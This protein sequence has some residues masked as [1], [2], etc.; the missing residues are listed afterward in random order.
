MANRFFVGDVDADFNDAGNWAATSGGA[1]GA[2]IPGV[3]D[4]VFF[5]ANSP[6]CDLD[7]NPNVLSVDFTAY[8]NEI[9]GLVAAIFFVGSGGAILVSTAT[10]TTFELKVENA[11][12]TIDFGGATIKNLTLSNTGASNRTITFTSSTINITAIFTLINGS[13]GDLT[14][15]FGINN[16]DFNLDSITGTEVS[17]GVIGINMGSGTWTHTGNSY[18]LAAMTGVF[19]TSTVT[20]QFNVPDANFIWDVDSGQEPHNL[21][22]NFNQA[23]NREFNVTNPS[24]TV[25]TITG[26]FEV[27]ILGAGDL[28]IDWLI[29]T[30][31]DGFI[32]EEASTGSLTLDGTTEIS[33]ITCLAGT[34]TNEVDLRGL[35]TITLVS[36]LNIGNASYTL[37]PGAVLLNIVDFRATPSTSTTHTITVA[38]DTFNI[39]NKWNMQF[40]N[41]PSSDSLNLIFTSCIVLM[42]FGTF[43][44]VLNKHPSATLDLTMGDQNWTVPSNNNAAANNHGM[45]FPFVDTLVG[46]S[47]ITTITVETTVS[48]FD[49][50][51]ALNDTVIRNAAGG[52]HT[53]TWA[54]GEPQKILGDLTLEIVAAANLILDYN[55]A[56]DFEIVSDFVMVNTSGAGTITLNMGSGLWKM[57][58]DI[59]IGTGATLIIASETSNLELNGL[60]L[61]T[62][63][64]DNI[65]MNTITVTNGTSAGIIF[66]DAVD[67]NELAADTAV[68]SSPI[69]IRFKAALSHVINA[70]TLTGTGINKINLRSTV[71]DTQWLLTVTGINVVDRVNVRDS[72]AS[73]SAID[74]DAL[75]STNFDASNNAGWDFGITDADFQI[76]EF[77]QLATAGVLRIP[78]TVAH[79]LELTQV[80]SVVRKQPGSVVHTLEF[81]QDP[82]I[83]ATW[84]GDVTHTL[85]LSQ[86]TDTEDPL[87]CVI[88]NIV[89]RD[90][91]TF[92]FPFTEM[93]NKVVMPAP[94]LGDEHEVHTRVVARHTRGGALRA[95][96]Q[97]FVFEVLNFTFIGL[98]RTKR[99]EIIAF[100]IVSRAD[101]VRFRD[102][103]NRVWRGMITS[104][105]TV[106]QSIGRSSPGGEDYTVAMSFEGVQLA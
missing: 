6:D 64:L 65:Q 106:L 15:D 10:Y 85:E 86:G 57:G 32:S 23:T 75:D 43:V 53:V 24:P 12:A 8:I 96:N 14:A 34:G 40:T 46:T 26:R 13:T 66:D 84:I 28:E 47:G 73:A 89:I 56:Q 61:Q 72:D 94:E 7:V 90:N 103:E 60:A 1:G 100:A 77:G 54:T 22:I 67:F 88:D 97:G 81:S 101:I 92:W 105:P 76:V 68:T 11:D 102:H 50:N 104:S 58:G 19:E 49:L 59:T 3:A 25:I 80:P 52:P 35:S 83:G 16:P 39:N 44:D 17:S 4:D 95:Y 62:V 29:Y 45:I 38:G 99:D 70:L 71:L 21:I 18:K 5:D 74:I 37:R 79:T 33:T 20:A 51:T 27:H 30:C 78:V 87:A 2:S 98:N 63:I 42:N 31:P 48:D 93:T 9:D 69:A 36:G 55:T 91:V 82:A 41:A